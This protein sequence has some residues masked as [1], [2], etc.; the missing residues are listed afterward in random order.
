MVFDATYYYTVFRDLPAA[1]EAA[2]RGDR[3]PL[4]RLA[5]DDE[6][7]N[8]GGGSAAS[9]SAG[10]LQAVSCHDYPTVWNVAASPAQRR[11]QLAAAIAR[12]GP[13]MFAPFPKSVWLSSL[14]ENE[15]VAGCL[16]WPKPAIP[17]PPFP[18]DL[19]YP[20]LPVLILDG[21]FD[22]ATPVEDALDVAR[23]WPDSTFVEVANSGHV[24]GQDDF[25][26]CTSA[27]LRR[28]MSGLR[29]GDTSCAAHIPPLYV[30]PD[31]PP[32]L[33]AAPSDLAWKIGAGHESTP[34]DRR[35]AWVTGETVGDAPLALVQ[36]GQHSGRRS[37]RRRL[38]RLRTL[39]GA[40]PVDAD[41]LELP[42]H[43]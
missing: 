19:R 13:G 32:R 15:L 8:A 22:Q 36:P 10:D 2:G 30:V 35:A 26:D 5:A 23:S 38:P 20:R 9:Y 16:D 31:F 4:L 37:L 34:A 18:K 14:D 43:L 39:P 25:L 40:P 1:L 7:G 3:R 6:A 42:L 24:T 12:L 11:R 17:D 29:A 21:E 28:F 41:V 33:A 27:I